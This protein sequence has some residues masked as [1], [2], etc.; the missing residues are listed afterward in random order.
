MPDAAFDD[1][2]RIF[3]CE[4]LGVSAGV[5]VRGAI[6]VALERNGGNGDDW[7]RRELLF[8]VVILRLPLG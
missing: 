5:R 4:F 3:P 8:E 7:A 1:P 2:V 6:S